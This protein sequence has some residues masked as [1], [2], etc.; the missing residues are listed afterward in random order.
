[1]LDAVDYRT[2]NSVVGFR[3]HKILLLVSTLNFD[4]K[5]FNEHV[6]KIQTIDSLG[7]DE[8]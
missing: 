5:S 4:S 7:E 1:M 2:V 3:G 6:I 8:N